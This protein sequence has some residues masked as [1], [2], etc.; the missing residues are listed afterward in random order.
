MD[1]KSFRKFQLEKAAAA[2]TLTPAQI[3]RRQA[4]REKRERRKDLGV[5]A[6]STGLGAELVRRNARGM[7]GRT[8][9][10]HGAAGGVAEDIRREGLRPR[11]DLGAAIKNPSVTET[12]TDPGVNE[13]SK[14][15]VFTTKSKGTARTYAGQSQAMREAVDQGRTA[16][17]GLA[18]YRNN[19]TRGLKNMLGFG[20]EDDSIATMDV[21]LWK[22]REQGR[23]VR[24]PEI[25]SVAENFGGGR[26]GNYFADKLLG[27]SGGTYTFE[28]GIGPEY[29]RGSDKYKKL[30]L[31]EIGEFIKKNPREFARYAAPTVGG[32]G[33]AGYGINRLMGAR[34]KRLEREKKRASLQSKVA[35]MAKEAAESKDPRLARAGVSGYNR[36]KRTPGH[37]T[38]SHIVVA[39]EGDRV[40][41]IRFGQQGV[42]TNQ[43]A[44]QREAFKSRHRKN[45]ARG[46]MSAA[47][48]AD[49]AKWSPKKTK[50]K[51]NP[52]WV[53]GS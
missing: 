10:Y 13:A 37:P 28:G 22:F 6:A 20:L 3:Q 53:K 16:A 12:V 14:G 24:N 31:G 42:R 17:E 49:K 34:K 35:E 43:T 4:R 11:S 33:L 30:S 51:D 29:V 44:G 9:L 48:W 15:L 27:E 7:T 40:K 39:K 26:F 19:P 38:K 46:K 52:N 41:T 8:R 36:P 23:V 50:D 21:P 18:D 47:Y 32:L 25:D 5:G 2:P 1:Y 45:I